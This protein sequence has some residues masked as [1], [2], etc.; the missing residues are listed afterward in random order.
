MLTPADGLAR[1]CLMLG[2]ASALTLA[3]VATWSVLFLA[4]WRT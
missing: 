4:L 3:T 2:G 1:D